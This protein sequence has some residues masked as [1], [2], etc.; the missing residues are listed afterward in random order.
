MNE[1]AQCTYNQL[2]CLIVFT[3]HYLSQESINRQDFIEIIEM[4][5]KRLNDKGK[6]WRHVY[7]ALT[8]LDYLLHAGSENVVRYFR[9]VFNGNDL[10]PFS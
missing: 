7:K 3:E 8:L 1:I 4:L 5:D 9:Y 2:S 10:K 6:N